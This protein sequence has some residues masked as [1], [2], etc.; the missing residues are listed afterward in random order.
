MKLAVV[1]VAVAVR[2]ALAVA[3]AAAAAAVVVVVV[4]VVIIIKGVG[5]YYLCHLRCR[6]VN[7]HR[8]T[9]WCF[10]NAV[11]YVNG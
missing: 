10:L 7:G 5:F 1:A 11:Q 4:I 8:N 3:A 9:L 6:L 2:V